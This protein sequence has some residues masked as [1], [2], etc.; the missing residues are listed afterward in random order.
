MLSPCLVLLISQCSDQLEKDWHYDQLCRDSMEL[1]PR[2]RGIWTIQSAGF[3][4][5]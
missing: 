3:H 2:Q 4:L 1:R 5:R